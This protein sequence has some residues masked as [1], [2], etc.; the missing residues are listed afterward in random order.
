MDKLDLETK[1]TEEP[2][3]L[4]TGEEIYY[5]RKTVETSFLKKKKINF[6]FHSIV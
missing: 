1:V 4:S 6:S 5:F 2:P 3:K